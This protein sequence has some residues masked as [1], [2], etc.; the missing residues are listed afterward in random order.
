MET[1]GRRAHARP[2]HPTTG[3]AMKRS[4]SRLKIALLV[5]LCLQSMQ[6]QC[7]VSS[8]RMCPEIEARPGAGAVNTCFVGVPCVIGVR[9]DG[10]SATTETRLTVAANASVLPAQVLSAGKG[11]ST[12][13]ALCMPPNQ[14]GGEEFVSVRVPLLQQA[15][16]HVLQLHRPIL[17][18]ITS[19]SD[20]LNFKVVASHG[21]L[22]PRQAAA[23]ESAR[24]G[25]AQTFTFTGRNLAALRIRADAAVLRSPDKS[26]ALNRTP[27]VQWMDPEQTQ[28]RVRLTLHRSGAVSTSEIFEFIGSGESPVNRQL[29]WPVI[30]VR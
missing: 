24:M 13:S 21:F 25:Q 9:G 15:G 17:F 10:V 28:V 19:E 3:A 20:S 11:T 23:S 1:N 29:G 14:P 30:Q 26:T 4:A 18:G 2:H 22:N 12:I 6:A 27:D 5:A 8:Y 7:A 16:D